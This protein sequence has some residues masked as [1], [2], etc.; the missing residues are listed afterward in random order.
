MKKRR[1][2]RPGSMP[3]PKVFLEEA[4]AIAVRLR[5]LLLKYLG[6][7]RAQAHS[8][9]VE[10]AVR[11]TTLI[12]KLSRKGRRSTAEKANVIAVK[13]EALSALLGTEIADLLSPDVNTAEE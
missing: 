10:D 11:L 2:R 1:V 5:K 9:R 8:G 3:R 4:E 6:T 13:V 12:E 7:Q